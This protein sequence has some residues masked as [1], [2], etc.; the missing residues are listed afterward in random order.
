M[1][2]ALVKT[3]SIDSLIEDYMLSITNKCENQAPI[4]KK[5]TKINDDKISIPTM[6]NY[7]DI[8]RYNY[9]LTQLKS[10]AK[11][12]KLKLSGNKNQLLIRVYS[13]LYFSSFIVKIQK[14]FR[15]NI[16]RKYIRL[17]GPGLLNKKLCTNTSDFVTLEPLQEIHFTQFFSYKDSDDFIYG[18]DIASLHSLISVKSNN[19]NTTTN[20]SDNKNPYNRNIIPTSVMVSLKNIIKLGRLL[21]F[22]VNLQVEDDTQ[23]ISI[24]KVVE[25]RAISLFQNIDA[26]GNY[27]NANWFLSLN[28]SQLTKFVRELHDIWS[29]RAQLSNE[30]KNN[31]CPRQGGP[32]RNLNI[33]YIN[34][35]QNMY[36]IKKVILEV[37]ENLVNSGVDRD[38]K[39]LGAYFVLGSLTL[40]STDAATA[41]PWLFQSVGYF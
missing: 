25:L 34:T 19:T 17:R 38:S 39:S 7:N 4:I 22:P 15:G 12:Y 37:M 14:L 5:P 13:F 40:V 36:N 28:R 11:H 35:E 23:S 16:T 2:I 1:S 41:L 32:F 30:T 18:F 24:E 29:Y 8:M 31:I 21:K 10:F 20:T 26:L 6:K 3:K 33:Q 27:S 9:N